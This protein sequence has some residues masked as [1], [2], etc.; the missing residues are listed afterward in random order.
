MDETFTTQSRSTSTLAIPRLSRRAGFWAVAF[1]FLAVTAFSTAPSSLYGL[2]EQS[3]HLSSLTITAV[4]AVYAVGVVVSL[5]LVGHVSDWYGRRVVMLPAIALVILAAIVFLAWRSLAG[6]FVARILTGLGLGAAVATATAFVTDLDSG[7]SGAATRRAGIVATIANIGGLACG[8]LIT[9]LLARYEPHGL[10]LPFE[11]YLVALVLGLLAVVFSPEGHPPDLPRPRYRP[12]HLALPANGRRQFVAATAG[13]FLCFAVFGLFAGLAG[14]FL[15]GP[16]H[17]PSPALCGLAI[18]LTFGAG[19]LVQI[20][21]TSWRAHRLIAAGIVPAIVGL[22]V[23]VLSAWTSPPSLALFLASGIIAGAGG[24]AIFRGSLT[25]VIANSDTDDRAAALATFFVAG[26]AGLSV[27]VIGLG[28]ALQHLSPRVTLLTF[29]LAVGLGML[30][31]SP[32][33]VRAP[34]TNP[35]PLR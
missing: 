8:P 14:R 29:G 15:A 11:F 23:L 28:I 12:Q 30:A 7:Q 9:G 17:H 25:L 10:T 13:A 22:G 19:V 33:L 4:Y 6:L 5:L 1:A 27:P 2:Y 20:T 18:F 34:D 32:A 26:Y 31:A 24:G 35:D 16:L 21:T 3:E